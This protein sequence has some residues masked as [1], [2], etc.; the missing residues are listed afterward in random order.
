VASAAE[1]GVA[2]DIPERRVG[3]ETRL[4]AVED[5]IS[6]RRAL[7]WFGAGHAVLA[8]ALL[9]Q[10]IALWG[11]GLPEWLVALTLGLPDSS[12]ISGGRRKARRLPRARRLSA[13]SASGTTIRFSVP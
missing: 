1:P 8:L 5:P 4:A 12:F 10:N 13:S 6:R 3:P 2:G 11:P 9:T 7:A